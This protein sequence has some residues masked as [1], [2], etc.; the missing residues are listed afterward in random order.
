MNVFV[1]ICPNLMLILLESSYQRLGKPI[2]PAG[3]NLT[4][5]NET[6]CNPDPAYDSYVSMV[7]ITIMMM[8]CLL[9]TYVRAN[10]GANDAFTNRNV[11]RQQQYTILSQTEPEIE[12]IVV[13]SVGTYV[14]PEEFGRRQVDNV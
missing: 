9:A 11:Q 5:G 3:L 4:R 6:Y 10:W 8:V 13:R 7:A 1:P 12:T 14:T 2:I